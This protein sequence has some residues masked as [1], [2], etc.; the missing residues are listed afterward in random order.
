MKPKLTRRAAMGSAAAGV[1]GLAVGAARR[2]GAQPGPSVVT[3]ALNPNVGVYHTKVG[4][5]DVTLI[6]DGTFNFKPL[7]PSLGGNVDAAQVEAFAKEF[8][9]PADGLAHVQTLLVRRGDRVALIDVGSGNTFVLTCGRVIDKLATLG[10]APA[11]VTD[12]LITHAHLDHVGGLIHAQTRRMAFPNAAVHVADAER[13]FWWSGPTLEKSGIPE[14][15]KA[16]V[17]G[18]AVEA[19]SVAESHLQTVTPGQEVVPGIT[20][21]DAAGHTPGHTIYR[22]A[23]GDDSL[24]F[25]GDLIFFPP[26]ITMNPDWYV[27]FDTDRV[28]AAATRFRML[29]Q[30]AADG[31]RICGSH[32]PFPAFGHLR[33]RGAGYEYLP[34]IWRFEN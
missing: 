12:V 8:H 31:Q 15:R 17:I 19:L 26:I 34:E 32:L 9:A 25:V 22:I 10:L 21:L 1:A 14:D 24:L 23:D 20:A 27:G 11:D 7:H 6:N 33:P 30:I 5:T 13:D 4:T 2:A 29:D 28:A 18:V 3:P 16:H